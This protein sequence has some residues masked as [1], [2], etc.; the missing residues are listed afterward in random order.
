MTERSLEITRK[1]HKMVQKSAAGAHRPALNPS[2]AATPGT[3]GPQP[4]WPMLPSHSATPAVRASR[5]AQPHTRETDDPR[6]TESPRGRIKS[7]LAAEREPLRP[8]QQSNRECFLRW[9]QSTVHR[10]LPDSETQT[11]SAESQGQARP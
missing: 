10:S 4:P 6:Q 5:Q 8:R 11:T 3:P 9:D 7:R 2:A 1:M